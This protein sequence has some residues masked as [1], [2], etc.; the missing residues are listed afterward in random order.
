M[1][2]AKS[3]PGAVPPAAPA[4]DRRRFLSRLWWL[5]SGVALAELVWL[6]GSF[7]R[8][9]PRVAVADEQSSLIV[10]GP[11]DRFALGSVTA[12]PRGRFY[13]VRL[14]DGGFLALH[15]RCTHLG[16]TVPWVETEQRFA[17]PCHASLFTITGE[18][19]GAPA[20]RPLDIFPV[21]IENRIVKVD[22]T[23]PVRRT[24]FRRDQAAYL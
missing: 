17:C 4:T 7:L 21:R 16:C 5:A 13:L 1:R 22:A 20:P 19:V 18:V 11:A 14:D 9:R 8:P 12:F 15:R 10:A 23:R 6:A 24:E 2:D 3:T